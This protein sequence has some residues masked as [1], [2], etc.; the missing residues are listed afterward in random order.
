M[1]I[2][3]EIHKSQDLQKCMMGLTHVDFFFTLCTLSTSQQPATMSK[4][5]CDDDDFILLF[6]LVSCQLPYSPLFLEVKLKHFLSSTELQRRD[7]HIQRCALLNSDQSPFQKLYHSRYKQSFITFKGLDY[8]TFEY[9][10]TK[11]R[12]LY[13]RYSPYSLNG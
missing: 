7:H 3:L 13:Q 4:S 9:L 2:N 5:S 1:T 6:L 12:P 8:A 10:L 11:F